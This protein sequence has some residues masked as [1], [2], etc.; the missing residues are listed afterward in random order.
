MVYVFDVQLSTKAADK[1]KLLI[2]AMDAGYLSEAD[3]WQHYHDCV[4]AQSQVIR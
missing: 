1:A 2:R 3:G 4:S